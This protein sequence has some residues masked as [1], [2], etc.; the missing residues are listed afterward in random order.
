MLSGSIAIAFLLLVG[1]PAELLEST[2]R[3]NYDRAF[4]W[5]AR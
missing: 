1:F 2:I 3:S 5:L 4:G